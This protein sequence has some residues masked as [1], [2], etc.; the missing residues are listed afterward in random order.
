MSGSLLA[1]GIKIK[2]RHGEK[3]KRKIIIEKRS[4]DLSFS[5]QIYT[6]LT[7]A[8]GLGVAGRKE[9]VRDLI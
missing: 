1:G 9:N 3:R 4:T 5:Q 8:V 2:R 6:L 7:A